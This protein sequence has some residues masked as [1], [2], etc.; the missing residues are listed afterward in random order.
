[1]LACVYGARSVSFV[2]I[3]LRKI[4]K[5]SEDADA[6]P[7]LRTPRHQQ[8]CAAF[9]HA[10]HVPEPVN[11]SGDAMK[12]SHNPTLRR[13]LFL[14]FACLILGALPPQACAKTRPP[15]DAGDPD[16]GN[17]KPS[18]GPGAASSFEFLSINKSSRVVVAVRLHQTSIVGWFWL[19]LQVVRPTLWR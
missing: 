8:F 13:L 3:R 14:F 19:Y 18:D 12:A 4:P 16:V 11:E 17:N 10:V 9:P 15:I 6:T 2:R 1:V 7:H 5:V